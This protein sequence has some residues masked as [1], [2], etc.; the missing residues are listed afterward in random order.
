LSKLSWIL[1]KF[2][3]SDFVSWIKINFQEFE[4]KK[5][6]PQAF[7]STPGDAS[8]LFRII[9][10]LG[11]AGEEERLDDEPEY[12]KDRIQRLRKIHSHRRRAKDLS[13]TPSQSH[14]SSPSH[15]DSLRLH[16]SQLFVFISFF[17][18]PLRPRLNFFWLHLLY[19]VTMAIVGSIVL[20]NIE[21]SVR[22]PY[23]DALFMA[24]SAVSDTGLT[25]F[26]FT[27][28]SLAG[29]IFILIWIQLGG[30]ILVSIVPILV[31]LAVSHYHL[32]MSP[33][34]IQEDVT[35]QWRRIMK[36]LVLFICI[37]LVS[38]QVCFPFCFN[39]FETSPTVDFI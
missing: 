16:L 21:D 8:A 19:F 10:M 22:L 6:L 33:I 11:V 34:Y 24:T 9:Q 27:L 3:E 14:P 29:K 28:F 1:I 2:R 26:D 15:Q 30:L 18:S 13:L 35:P 36:L 5:Y 39:E 20:W 17:L 7:W 4:K 37:F 25:S 12:E 23:I 31:R 38:V 32:P